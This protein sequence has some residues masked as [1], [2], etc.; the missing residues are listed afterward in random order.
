M[1]DKKTRPER[2]TERRQMGVRGPRCV[3]MG[4]VELSDVCEDVRTLS[5]MLVLCERRF[6]DAFAGGDIAKAEKWAAAGNA[7]LGALR[8]P[9]PAES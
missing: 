7:V 6:A 8:P 5:R 2:A 4:R 9:K 3:S 1:E